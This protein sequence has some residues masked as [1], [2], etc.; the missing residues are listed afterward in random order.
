MTGLDLLLTLD[1][2]PAKGA[3]VGFLGHAASL[4][5]DGRHAVEHLRNRSDWN[6]VCLFSPEHGFDGRAAAGEPVDH[7][8][9]S[10]WEL[11][12]FSLYGDDRSPRE[13]WLEGLDLLI[14]D[15]MDLG[16]R[17]YTY[18]STLRNV[19]QVCARIGLPL[20]ILDRPTPLAGVMDGPSLDPKLRSFVGAVDLPTVYG[21][22]QGLLAT[23]LQRHDPTCAGADLQVIMSDG[24]AT[25][26]IPPSPALGTQTSAVCY[27]LTV[28]SEAIPEVDVDRGGPRSFQVWSMPDLPAEALARSLHGQN[29]V[30]VRTTEVIHQDQRWPGLQFEVPEVNTYLPVSFAVKM[31][32]NL[33]RHLGPDRLFRQTGARPDFFDQLMGTKSVRE[34]LCAGIRS[35]EITQHWCRRPGPVGDG[36]PGH[37]PETACE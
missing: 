20:L 17:C 18:A 19:M 14:T 23:W 34:A 29:G 12:V 15:L 27:P 37:S 31:L 11:P 33:C 13:E 7:Q 22:S 24:Q 3:R 28:W 30:Q 9:D 6:L 36:L 35:S 1:P 8:D 10:P 16:V 4:A 2:L 21:W 26:W 25:E 32:E 5:Q